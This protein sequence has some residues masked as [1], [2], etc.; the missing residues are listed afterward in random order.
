MLGR[1]KWYTRQSLQVGLMIVTLGMG[2]MNFNL[3]ANELAIVVSQD[4]LEIKEI[5]VEVTPKSYEED[6][7]SYRFQVSIPQISSEKY[8]LY[9]KA[10]NDK[11]NKEMQDALELATQRGKEYY[12]AYLA[13]G[14]KESDYRPVNI[15]MDYEVRY[16]KE[17]IVS[18]GIYKTET[19]GS[20]YDVAYFYNFDLAN[21][22]D[23]T[24]KDFYGED[25][26]TIIDEQIMSQMKERIAQEGATYFE[27]FKGIE[28]DQAFY[29]NEK[30]NPV[31]V[32]DKYEI[33][34]GFMGMQSFEIATPVKLMQ[35]EPEAHYNVK[36]SMLPNNTLVN[37]PKVEG[38]KGEILQDY[39]NQ[40]LYR[41]VEKYQKDTYSN[42]RLDYKITRMDDRILSVL[43]RGS[44]DIEG[45]GTKMFID[46]INLDLSQDK[47]VD[48]IN[49]QNFILPTQ[50]AQTAFN[51]IL[52]E[53]LKEQGIEEI[54]VEGLRVYF[55]DNRAVFYYMI[56][57]DSMQEVVEVVIPLVELEEIKANF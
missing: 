31:I 45:L 37:Y 27:G 26:K 53:K 52:E 48:E 43:Y 46:S 25:Y 32:F 8:S 18:L 47:T 16:N 30:G 41:V 29:I 34:P 24:L 13:T 21:Q 11:I 33:A 36:K 17:G 50:E 55:K 3:Y 7:K 49:A 4:R 40:S 44:V 20:A 15:Q 19:I 1:S 39:I 23:I 54:E 6:T 14:G 51:K 10:I 28:E 12:E 22:K 9:A 5:N 38:Y 57:D 35:L 56:P 42:L 2:G